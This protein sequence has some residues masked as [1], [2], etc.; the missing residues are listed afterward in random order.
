MAGTF[1]YT[2]VQGDGQ[3]LA[4]TLLLNPGNGVEPQDLT[5]ATGVTCVIYPVGGAYSAPTISRAATIISP[6]TLGEVYVILTSADSLP[7]GSYNVEWV[8]TFT[9][10][11]QRT[12]PGSSPETMIV[13]AR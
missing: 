2:Y 3:E 8:V 13:R 10:G 1:N 6:A 9:G 7:A 11:I 4:T 12:W 5:S